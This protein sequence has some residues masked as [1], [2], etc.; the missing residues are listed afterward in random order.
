MVSTGISITL[1]WGRAECSRATSSNRPPLG[2]SPWSFEMDVKASV[3]TTAPWE[4][5]SGQGHSP[6]PGRGLD[7]QCG[8]VKASERRPILRDSVPRHSGIIHPED[9]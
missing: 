1:T 8:V 5:I 4:E 6:D 2:P 9:L 7:S 3:A